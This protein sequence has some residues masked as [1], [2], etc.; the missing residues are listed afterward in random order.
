MSYPVLRVLAFPVWIAF[1]LLTLAAAPALAALGRLASLLSGRPQPLALVRLL[2]V[3]VTGELA[4]LLSPPTHERR[5]RQLSRFLDDV[6]R[7]ALGSL[8]VNVRVTADAAAHEALTR[9][10]RPLLVFS[11]HAGA[12]DSVLLVHLLLTRYGREPGIVLKELLTVDPV[13][14]MV[15]RH[16]PSAL[17]DGADDDADEIEAAARALPPNGAL[18]LFPEGGNFTAQ[19]RERAIDWLLGNGQPERAARAQRLRHTIAP[20]PRGVLAALAGA[21]AADV[22]FAAHAGLGEREIDIPRDTT[23]HIRL[24]HVPAAEI[25]GTDAARAGWLDDW[26]ERLDG[27]VAAADG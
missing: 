12:G 19:R 20:R 1:A 18:L 9:H 6:V 23:V 22:I 27:W 10:D 21:R 4:M 25:P 5:L 8:R 26:W 16:L 13:V 2:Y 24:W 15:A 17:I 3:Y 7:S 11:R 14:G